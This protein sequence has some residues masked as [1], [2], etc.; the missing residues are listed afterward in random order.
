LFLVLGFFTPSPEIMLS[1]AGEG[2]WDSIKANKLVISPMMIGMTQ[3][4]CSGS[5]S[6]K[7]V[8]Y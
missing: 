7:Q 4:Q 3:R 1:S 2:G 8:D 5:N 6:K